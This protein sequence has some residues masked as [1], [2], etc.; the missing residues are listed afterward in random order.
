MLSTKSWKKGEK[1]KHCCGWIGEGKGKNLRLFL[2]D[3]LTEPN[4]QLILLIFLRVWNAFLYWMFTDNRS[5]DGEAMVKRLGQKN[6]ANLMS[7]ELQ[8]IR[9]FF[10]MN[11]MKMFCIR[12]FSLRK[13]LEPLVSDKSSCFVSFHSRGNFANKYWTKFHRHCLLSVDG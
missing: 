1:A 3:W 8:R 2:L 10:F 12:L 13:S 5:L 6:K 4:F 11:W 9:S 7:A